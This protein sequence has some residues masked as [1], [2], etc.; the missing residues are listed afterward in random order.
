[1]PAWSQS[2][3]LVLKGGGNRT[4]RENKG[5][6][7][8]FDQTVIRERKRLEDGCLMPRETLRSRLSGTHARH[9]LICGKPSR[10]A[11]NPSAYLQSV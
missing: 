7:F 8:A 1:M 3:Q 4:E 6:G 11:T 2:A 5:F 9:P 10:A